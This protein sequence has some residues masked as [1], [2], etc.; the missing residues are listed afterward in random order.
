MQQ[1][2]VN[3][4]PKSGGP[5]EGSRFVFKDGTTTVMGQTQLA[6]ETGAADVTRANG[7][8]PYGVALGHKDT[9]Y[10]RDKLGGER[11]VDIVIAGPTW[12]IAGVELD[13]TNE[14]HNFVTSDANGEAVPATVATDFVGG[15]FIG[16]K[17]VAV[18]KPALIYV[19]PR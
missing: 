14:A 15:R 19:D 4:F 7:V 2:I 18:G 9:T 12:I 6:F 10:D 16:T 5:I 17:T 3:G 1:E 13:P 8:M 11:P